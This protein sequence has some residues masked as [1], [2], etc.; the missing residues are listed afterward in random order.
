MAGEEEKEQSCSDVSLSMVSWGRGCPL[1]L[2]KARMDLKEERWS[3]GDL[4]AW[5]TDVSVKV[6][7]QY[8]LVACARLDGEAT[9]QVGSNTGVARDGEG[10]GGGGRI[11][12]VERVPENGG[13]CKTVGRS[14]K[15]KG[16]GGGGLTGGS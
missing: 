14:G 13:G 12:G 9:R 1:D 15:G 3:V 6:G 16:S 4:E 7:D 8:A 11:G 10:E 5:E 2:K